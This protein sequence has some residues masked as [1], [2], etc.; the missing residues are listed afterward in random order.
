MRWPAERRGAEEGD[1]CFTSAAAYRGTLLGVIVE[2]V[3]G[4]SESESEDGIHWGR[5]CGWAVGVGVEGVDR[6]NEERGDG[7]VFNGST[8]C[9]LLRW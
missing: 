3:R 7:G 5:G 9:T 1:V 6:G 8:V 4:V 2:V